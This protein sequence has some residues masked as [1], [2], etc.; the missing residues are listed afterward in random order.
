MI[1]NSKSKKVSIATQE[2]YL[3]GLDLGPASVGW[4]VVKCN[5]MGQPNGLVNCGV[6]RFD[7]GVDGGSD[8]IAA[9]RDEPRALAR[10]NAR[11]LRRS[12]WRRRRRMRKLYLI[13]AANDF[14]PKTE[15]CNEARHQALLELDA[16]LGKKLLD[17]NCRAD[18]HRLA[19]VLRAKALEDQVES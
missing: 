15:D 2:S 1:K 14:L 9:G 10:R 13:L 17:E 6:R 5:K 11:S 8:K 12:T 7:A 3:L 4:A 18:Q 16:E 19:Y